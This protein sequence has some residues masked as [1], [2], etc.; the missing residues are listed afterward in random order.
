MERRKKKLK[1][2][3]GSNNESCGCG[4]ASTKGYMAHFG[5]HKLPKNLKGITEK[6]KRRNFASG[7][8]RKP[9]FFSVFKS[10]NRSKKSDDTLTARRRRALV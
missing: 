4:S 1:D 7:S 6:R 5:V 10:V 9:P 2:N 8:A 3:V